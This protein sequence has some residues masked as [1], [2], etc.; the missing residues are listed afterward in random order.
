[1]VAVTGILVGL[2]IYVQTKQSQTFRSRSTFIQAALEGLVLF[3][4][5][6][7]FIQAIL[8]TLLQQNQGLG[9][10]VGNLA[11]GRDFSQTRQASLKIVYISNALYFNCMYGIKC[12]MILFYWTFLISTTMRK[13]Y[14]CLQL[15]AFFVAAAW[16]SNLLLCFFFCQPISR[17][18]S[19]DPDQF[20]GPMGNKYVYGFIYGP[21]LAT[22]LMGKS[23]ISK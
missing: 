18:W 12:H 20:C 9:N 14:R 19:L 2:R 21:H 23:M 15:T 6:S 11:P 1:M 8:D 10:G 4:W 13:T 3:S 5:F 17:N 7:F 16:L 22:D